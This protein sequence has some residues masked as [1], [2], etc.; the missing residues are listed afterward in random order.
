MKKVLL[1]SL[2]LLGSTVAHADSIYLDNMSC[3]QSEFQ[4]FDVTITG[5][6]GKNDGGTNNFNSTN[7]YYANAKEDRKD[8]RMELSFSYRFGGVKP[9]N[10]NRLYDLA[11]QEKQSELELLNRK[12]YA[13]KN[14][15]NLDWSN[16]SK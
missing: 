5:S 16:K 1:T 7:N 9:I 10:C 12:I 8:N 6:T 2:I 4:P 13:F 3:T 11:I 14:L 15:E